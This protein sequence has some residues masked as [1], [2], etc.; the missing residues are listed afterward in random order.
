MTDRYLSQIRL[1]P[2]V[3]PSP[4]LIQDLQAQDGGHR[5]VWRLFSD[6][7]E[8][9]PF[10]YRQEVGR[11][12]RLVI[13]TLSS[14]PPQGDAG[15]WQI[16]TK[17]WRPQLEVG[18]RLRFSLRANPTR[19]RRTGSAAGQRVDVIQDTLKQ[20]PEGETRIRADVVHEACA[21]WLNQRA[22]RGG[23]A[24]LGGLAVDNEQHLRFR[25]KGG[26]DASLV[27]VDFE[28]GLEVTDP[29]RFIEAV[30]SG[31]GSGKAFGA[32]LMLLRRL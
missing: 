31:V 30:A 28:G 9:R 6:H 4:Q 22:E 20:L 25:R 27:T 16:A 10:L 19:R 12:G 32:G 13:Y 21:G 17:P 1:R 3:T 15:H 23:F 5:L 24:L 14:V 2:R 18:A 8:P 29:D 7:A 11:D 26:R